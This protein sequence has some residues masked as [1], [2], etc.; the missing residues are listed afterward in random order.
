MPGKKDTKVKRSLDLGPEVVKGDT[1]WMQSP[2]PVMRSVSVATP[3]SHSSSPM[4]LVGKAK[5]NV[6][7]TSA[8]GEV[9]KQFVIE[10][11]SAK[12]TVI[13]H[14]DRAIVY[15]PAHNQIIVSFLS[16]TLSFHETSNYFLL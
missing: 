16:V 2:L 5:A 8:T 14:Y 3:S 11:P 13:R 15:V 1:A 6:K 9:A 12:G 4:P 10:S 7:V